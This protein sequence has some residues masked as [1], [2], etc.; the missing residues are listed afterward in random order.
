[1]KFQVELLSAIAYID[2]KTN[3]PKTRLG[4][5]CLETK[6]R[7]STEKM[8]GF[9]E[10][11]VYLDTHDVFNKLNSDMFGIQSELEFI[12][13]PNQNNP[14]KNSLELKTIKVGNNVINI[15]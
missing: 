10:L 11:C 5:R 13:K 7:Q 3:L 4:Y 12:E 9:S 15:L 14:L 6:Y 8:K 1:M 2:K